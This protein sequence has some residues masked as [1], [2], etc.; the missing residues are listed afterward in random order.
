MYLHTKWYPTYVINIFCL[1]DSDSKQEEFSEDTFG[2]YPFR[3]RMYSLS[4]EHGTIC[5]SVAMPEL[6]YT[7]LWTIKYKETACD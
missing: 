6:G 5:C 3:I 4:E 2:P 7:P 1:Q